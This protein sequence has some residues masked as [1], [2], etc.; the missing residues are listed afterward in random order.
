M[1]QTKV[2]K[3]L[4]GL[5][6]KPLKKDIDYIIRKYKIKIPKN[7]NTVKQK[8][9]FI[10]KKYKIKKY[11][12]F[13]EISV[14]DLKKLLKKNHIN[15]IGNKKKMFLK[16]NNFNKS[17]RQIQS[18]FFSNIGKRDYQE[19]RLSIFNNTQYYI[20]CVYDG[21]GGNK[22]SVFLKNN[23]YKTFIKNFKQNPPIKA[24]FNTFLQ[25]NQIFL[26]NVIGR[27]GSTANVLF[28][29]KLTNICYVANTG[30]S[31]AILCR[32]NGSVEQISED[33]KPDNLTEKKRIQSRGG[34]VQNGRV[35]GNLAMS[36]SFGDK[37]I[38]NVLT[39]EPDIYE[40]GNRNIKFILQAS[41]GLFDVM[42]NYEVCK[43][44][45]IRLNRAISPQNIAKELVLYA[46][47][48]RETQ[49]NTSLI[50]SIF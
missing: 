3:Y 50:I 27:D 32:K 35:N 14:N 11:H 16:F 6:K 5:S 7:R 21:H 4:N 15:Y 30:D 37:N 26:N 8:Y 17:H 41:D 19:D 49:D 38:A 29:N 24:L 12:L 45:N 44:I 33:H 39:V 2:I 43:F 18:A 22:C 34:F 25:L 20:S 1:Q 36:R 28:Y 48:T 9:T 47:N 10:K 31:R 13:H 40:F 46:I 23:F 42:S